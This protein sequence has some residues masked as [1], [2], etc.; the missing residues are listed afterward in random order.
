ML[1]SNAHR[2]SAS[3]AKKKSKKSKQI[4]KA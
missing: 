2:D 1:R 3:N 4:K